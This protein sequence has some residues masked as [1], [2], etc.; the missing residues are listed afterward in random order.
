M[1]EKREKQIPCIVGAGVVTT[2]KDMMRVLRGFDHVKYSD[3]IDEKG[4][5]EDE[6]FVVEVFCNDVESTIFFNRRIYI[7]VQ[8]FEYLKIVKSLPGTI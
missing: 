1:T 4:Q 2:K 7:N 5:S 8:N 6:A 3:I